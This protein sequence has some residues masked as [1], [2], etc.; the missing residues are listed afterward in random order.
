MAVTAS[1]QPESGR[2]VNAK[3]D[4]LHPFRFRFSTEGMDHIVQNRPGSDLDGLVR[5]GQNISGLE[6]SWCAGITGPGF[7]QG[8]NR[9]ATSSPL[10]DS[11][12]FFHRHPG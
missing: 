7:W 12:S 1:V 8:R 11:V 6:V 10:S 3:F 5:A 9:P 2:I 4:F